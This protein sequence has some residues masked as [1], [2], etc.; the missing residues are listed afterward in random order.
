MTEEAESV[1]VYHQGKAVPEKETAEML[2]MIPCR[3]GG[4]KDRAQEFAG[5]V[6]HGQQQGLLLISRPPLMDG[7]IVLPQFVKA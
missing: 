6:I 1:G 7:G 2:E 5:M 3:I 4:D